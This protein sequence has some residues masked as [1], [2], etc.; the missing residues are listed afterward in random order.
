[1]VDQDVPVSASNPGPFEVARVHQLSDD[2]L[3]G[4][5]GDIQIVGN[6][7]DPGFGVLGDAQEGKPV[8]GQ[9]LEWDHGLGLPEIA[10][11]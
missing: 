10:I 8:V 5:L 4:A 1:M 9:E 11:R 7:P 3:R 6:I 2:S